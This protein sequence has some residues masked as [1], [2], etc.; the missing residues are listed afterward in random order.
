[1]EDKSDG[2][3]IHSVDF[4]VEKAVLLSIVHK[5]QRDSS[6]NSSNTWDYISSADWRGFPTQ[7]LKNSN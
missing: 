2:R 4:Y 7:D 5:Q 6:F 1:M 3:K